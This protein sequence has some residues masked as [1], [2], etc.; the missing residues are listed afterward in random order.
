MCTVLYLSTLECAHRGVHPS[1]TIDFKI[2]PST[3]EET[4]LL[5]CP[6]QSARDPYS[7]ASTDQ[8]ANPAASPAFGILYD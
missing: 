4:Q 3:L 2:F 7:Q 5:S 1:I 8:H 6:F